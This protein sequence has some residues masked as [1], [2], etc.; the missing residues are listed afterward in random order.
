MK[1]IMMAVVLISAL[2]GLFAQGKQEEAQGDQLA[3]IKASGQITVAMEGD[4]APW[5]FHDENDKLVGFDTEVASAIADKLGVKAS[6]V[7]GAWDGLFAGLDSGRYDMIANGVEITDERA[8]K[9]DFSEPYGYI[10]TSL[11]VRDDNTDIK[12]F[13]DLK[14]KK[15]ANSIASTY[16][17]LAEQYGAKVDS[18]DTLDETI[19]VVL[20]GRVDATL[21]ADVSIADYLRV[22]PEAKIRIVA[23]YPDPS[24]VA[25]PLRK[26]ADSASLKA[27]VDQ[28]IEE[29]RTDGTLKAISEKYFGIDITKKN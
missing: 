15:T 24:R 4:W 8:Q 14:G 7:E 13:E 26:G 18:V 20:A 17:L 25:I 10:H 6:F 11:V 22:H 1:K 29:L 3:R 12:S 16:M 9:Y 23:N 19:A 27:A 2:A 5:T 28:A 21:N